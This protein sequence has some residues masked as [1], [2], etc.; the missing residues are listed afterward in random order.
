M[1]M[2][3]HSGL[4]RNGLVTC[5]HRGDFPLCILCALDSAWP[6]VGI[7]GI[8][9]KRVDGWMKNILNYK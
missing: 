8:F 9:D 4:L 5:H 1:N 2:K 3:C 6:K 7:Q